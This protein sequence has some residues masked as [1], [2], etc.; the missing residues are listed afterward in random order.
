MMR[1]SSLC[2]IRLAAGLAALI[3]VAGLALP[4]ITGPLPNW[5]WS[6]LF[7]A[8][9]VPVAA[10][11]VLVARVERAVVRALGVCDQ[12]ADGNYDVRITAVPEGGSLG[13][14]FIRIN[15]TLDMADCFSRE[16]G[17]AMEHASRK[18]Y[19]RKVTLTGLRGCF[20]SVARSINHSVEDME[21]RDR[22]L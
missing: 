17:A 20:R 10:I 1:S 18:L 4:F 16:V 8:V 6:A 15:D 19:Y 13:R 11:P 21:A 3:A 9:L 22:V 5:A 12:T 7:A 2:R 14:L